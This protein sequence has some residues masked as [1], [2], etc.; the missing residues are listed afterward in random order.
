MSKKEI[1]KNNPAPAAGEPEQEL[2]SV[3]EV[4]G[5]RWLWY[6]VCSECHGYI[7]WNQ[8]YCKWCNRRINWNE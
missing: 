4:E 8:K 3:P 6:Y 1:K 5:D 7:D 2:Y